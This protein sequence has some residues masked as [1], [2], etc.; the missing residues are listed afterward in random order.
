M[1]CRFVFDAVIV[2]FFAGLKTLSSINTSL[3]VDRNAFLEF[4]AS[5]NVVDK[6]L[7]NVHSMQ[8]DRLSSE[9]LDV[10][11]AVSRYTR[12]EEEDFV[13]FQ[14]QRT[15][16]VLG[17]DRFSVGTASQ[18]SQIVER[19]EAQESRSAIRKFGNIHG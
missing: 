16:R 8:L 10:D 2:K 9:S 13:G 12:L 4:D 14:H 15:D 5:E 19:F 11:K 6:V 18:D 17:I 7:L 1:E 3:L